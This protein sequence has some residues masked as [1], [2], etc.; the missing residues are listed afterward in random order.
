MEVLEL[1]QQIAESEVLELDH[2]Q[3][4]E[5]IKHVNTFLRV[6]HS[7]SR[8]IIREKDRDTLLKE[9][10]KGLIET[11][12]YYDAWI[13]L[14]DKSGSLLT[15][16]E[17]GLGKD[18][19]P[20]IEQLKRGKLPDCC[21]RAMRQ[22]DVVIT[23][24]PLSICADCPFLALYYER[25]AITVR[26]EY[27]GNIYGLFS[28][29]VP[30]DF[31]TDEEE[32]ALFEEIALDLSFALHRI[33]LDEERKRV[34]KEKKKLE[35]Q[36]KYAQRM[37]TLSTLAGGMAHNFNNLLMGIQGNAS[38]V[39]L[40]T[41]SA[42]PSYK[43]LK[44]IEKQVQTGT[45]L[46]GQLLGYAREGRYEVKPINVNQVAKETSDAFGTS[47]KDIKV[48]QGFAK[49]LWG[50]KADQGQI[51][52]VFLSLYGNASDTMPGGG[53]L[54]LKTMNVTEKDMKNK[55][56]EVKSGNYVFLTVTDTGTGMDKETV[57]RIFE[58]FFT[59]KGM[60]KSTGLGL[61]SA[62]GIIKAHG[63]YID[64][65]SERGHGTNFE[66]Y[67]PAFKKE[68]AKEKEAATEVLDGKE[69][70]LL[71]DDEN[72]IIDVW[73]EILR[74]LGY[75]VLIASGGIEAL[76]IYKKNKDTIDIVILDMIMPDIGGG[77]IYDRVKEIN[78]DIKVLLS[79]GYSIN[80]Q[81]T[82]MLNRGCSGF[83]QKPFNMKQLAEK[84][85]EILDS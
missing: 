71:V 79:S 8:L 56:Y 84:I 49:D 35:S 32:Q 62:Y 27:E 5:R 83:I 23:K 19:L 3:A 7:V 68:E 13:A 37:K 26:L 38:L 73:K 4:E 2:R 50:I 20:M 74:A 36:L 45:K 10:C 82:E 53:D 44:N 34:E 40:E 64:V 30:R 69:T 6:I 61:A 67:L 25:G 17:A 78:P 33:E 29:S 16:A 11:S 14:L 77:E 85:R 76:E 66:I 28:V 12:C 54:F 81:A 72:V 15:T 58:P 22:S 55:P 46:T 80:G 48:Y 60:S 63:G 43:R 39:L 57:E 9:V 59:T 65:Y 51:E 18:F 70:V 41:D 42:H 21:Q 31:V 1:R 75:K 52:Q 24:D 47:R